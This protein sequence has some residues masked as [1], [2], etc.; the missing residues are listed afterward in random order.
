MA[1]EFRNKSL[2]VVRIEKVHINMFSVIITDNKTIIHDTH[3]PI[4]I[5]KQ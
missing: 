5:H 1:K 4:Y 3:C 2:T